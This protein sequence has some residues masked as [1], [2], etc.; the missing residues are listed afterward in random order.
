MPSFLWSS[1]TTGTPFPLLLTSEKHTLVKPEMEIKC[2]W[3]SNSDFCCDTVVIVQSLSHV[4]L[5]ATPWT[6]A[7]QASLSFTISWSMLNSC[8][9]SQW[10]HPTILPSV[11]PLSSCLQSFPESGS[12][13]IKWN[14]VIIS[15]CQPDSGKKKKISPLGPDPLSICRNVTA[16]LIL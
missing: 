9:L 6:A 1:V 13:Q 11:I 14:L 5:S 3:F 12:F 16:Y 10:C 2:K 15:P 4:W 7:C 8:P